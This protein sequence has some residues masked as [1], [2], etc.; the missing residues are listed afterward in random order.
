MGVL[1]AGTYFTGL[2]PRQYLISAYLT[3][4]HLKRHRTL[5]SPTRIMS[6]ADKPDT[7]WYTIIGDYDTMCALLWLSDCS[8]KSV[9]RQ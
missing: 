5:R 2:H 1:L 3:D 8:E 6:P 4:M 9:V 7:S